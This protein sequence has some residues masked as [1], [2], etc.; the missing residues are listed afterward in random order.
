MKRILLI[1]VVV[2]L[3]LGGW[4]LARRG[5]RL[6]DEERVRETLE[7]ARQA[8]EARDLGRFM[9]CVSPRYDD[10]NHT[11]ET[12]RSM[13]AFGLRQYSEVRVALYVRE[14]RV[15]GDSAA[16]EL[17]VQARGVHQSGDPARYTGVMNVSLARDEVRRHV[18][19]KEARWR[20][21]GI[22]SFGDV[23]DAFSH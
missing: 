15:E 23:Q 10:G 6:S 1:G 8:V 21:V 2:A 22:D 4:L 7:A 19:F 13:M 5:P 20:A 9:A 18:F 14:I 3:A 17:D 16:A 12:L 11:Y